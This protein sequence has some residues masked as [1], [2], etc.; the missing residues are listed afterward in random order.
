MAGFDTVLG[1]DSPT[2]EDLLADAA[3]KY[4]TETGVIVDLEQP[5]P[6]LDLL[7]TMARIMKAAYDDQAGVYAS[8]FV[9][10]ASGAGLRNLLLPYIG[11]P[12]QDTPSTVTLPLTGTPATV[13]T[14]GSTVLL[15]SDGTNALPWVLTA[16][17]VIPN[18]G[19][20]E[21]S[22][23]GPKSATA[24]NTWTIGT[25]VA[26]WAG[27]GP[28]ADDASKGRLAETDNEY[29]Q[30]FNLS[31]EGTR[32]LAAV[33]QVPGVTTA[34]VFENFTG[35]N[36]AFWG[37]DHWIEILVQGGDDQAIAQA[38]QNARTFT[39][40]PLGNVTEPVIDPRYDAGSVQIRFSRPNLVDVWTSLTITKGEGYSTDTSAAAIAA[41]EDAIR[42]QILTW[43]AQ[44]KVGLD[45]SAF[46][47][48]AQA[49]QTPTVPGIA[50]IA[51]TVDTVNPPLASSVVAG[52]RDLLVFDASRILLF[53]V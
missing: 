11:P 12:L 41:R 47:V 5:S 49:S 17:V 15:D 50:D 40:Y 29:R 4:Q 25:P 35:I 36:D 30:R 21:Y 22:E 13:V 28:N 43:A 19:V 46:Q 10:T 42:T 45:V 48:A 2:F 31:V 3:Q 1:F 7:R 37:Q 51:A 9:G 6:T 14:A 27:A 24:G 34:R 53:G 8:G 16:N 44:R 18:D 20:F 26:G 39:V 38:I 32:I 23:P 52:P 33:L